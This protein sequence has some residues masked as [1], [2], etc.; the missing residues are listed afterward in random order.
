MGTYQHKTLYRNVTGWAS[1]DPVL[2]RAEKITRFDL[3]KFATEVP[4][5]WYQHDTAAMSRLTTQLDERTGRN[6]YSIPKSNN[7]LAWAA[8]GGSLHKL[9]DE[10]HF[11]ADIVNISTKTRAFEA[12]NIPARYVADKGCGC[13]ISIVLNNRIVASDLEFSI[14]ASDP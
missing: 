12:G 6:F 1:F 4:P 8:P 5:E 9:G 10:Y 3:W 7:R 11:E 2:S 14:K 13:A